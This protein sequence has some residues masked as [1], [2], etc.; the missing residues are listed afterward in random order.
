MSFPLEEFGFLSGVLSGS[1]T[2]CD[3][4]A[5][6]ERLW[7]A[8]HASRS[9]RGEGTPLAVGERQGGGPLGS[10]EGKGGGVHGREEVGLL[11]RAGWGA[12]LGWKNLP[13]AFGT[14]EGKRR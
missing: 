6:L 13:T 14:N 12:I 10:R 5:R 2:A 3:E 11:D 9:G 7:R 4:E 8:C 1:L